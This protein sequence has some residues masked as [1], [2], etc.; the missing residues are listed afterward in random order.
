LTGTTP[1]DENHDELSGED[2]SEE[3]NPR[4]LANAIHVGRSELWR[5]TLKT[6]S[7]DELRPQVIQGLT[8]VGLSPQSQDLGG[9]QVPGGIEFD[10]T[11]PQKL[12]P[13]IKYILEKLAPPSKVDT[14]RPRSGKETFT[15]Y[16]VKSKRKLP[17]GTS[18]VVIWLSQPN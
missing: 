3:K 4:E 2:D 1:G 14:S 11:V 6:V 10:M 7:P 8:S 15:W 18:Q 17:E 5:F 12:V 16:K 9:T 13:E